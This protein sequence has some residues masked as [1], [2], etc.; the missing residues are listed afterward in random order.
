MIELLRDKK[1]IFFDVG[2]KLDYPSSGDWMF[3]DKFYELVNDKLKKRSS[4]EI[5]RARNKSFE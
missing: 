4:E 1:V 5:Q 2:Y 3:T